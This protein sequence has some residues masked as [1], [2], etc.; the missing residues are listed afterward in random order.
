MKEILTKRMYL[1][2]TL[3]VIFECLDYVFF[4]YFALEHRAS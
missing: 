1:A 3:D 4:K 2:V